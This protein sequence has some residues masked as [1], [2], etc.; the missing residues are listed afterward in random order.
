MQENHKYRMKS[1]YDD[2][3]RRARVVSYLFAEKRVRNYSP[4]LLSARGLCDTCS[5]GT[6]SSTSDLCLYFPPIS[7]QFFSSF[8]T[9]SC[10]VSK[11]EEKISEPSELGLSKHP[12][13]PIVRDGHEEKSPGQKCRK[14]CRKQQKQ[15]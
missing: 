7:Y 10:N 8:R 13:F 1:L 12:F 3:L 6:T 9:R 14:Q 4:P 15:Q 5:S 11:G 2:E